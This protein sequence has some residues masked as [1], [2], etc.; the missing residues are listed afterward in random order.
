VKFRGVLLQIDLDCVSQC[1][2]FADLA[3]RSSRPVNVHCGWA[4]LVVLY[5][6]KQIAVSPK[7]FAKGK[8]PSQAIAALLDQL[9]EEATGVAV[10]ISKEGQVGRITLPRQ[11]VCGRNVVESLIFQDYKARE[12][13]VFKPAEGDDSV[14]R[15]GPSRRLIHGRQQ[16]S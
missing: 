9:F 16:V 4:V 1:V 8:Y 2:F 6:T 3:H 10:K 5:P 13:Q 15:I 11:S 7:V 12:M 14:I